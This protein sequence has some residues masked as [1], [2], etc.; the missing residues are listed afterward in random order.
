MSVCVCVGLSQSAPYISVSV[1]VQ[2]VQPFERK[3][4]EGRFQFSRE[5]VQRWF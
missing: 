4:R 1:K 3:V 2:R 5:K